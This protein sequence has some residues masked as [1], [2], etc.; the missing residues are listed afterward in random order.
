MKKSASASSTNSSFKFNFKVEEE[1]MEDK[2]LAS[3][4]SKVEINKTTPNFNFNISDNSFRFNFTD[5]GS[6]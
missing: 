1:S 4:L 5:D 3:C 2:K 6:L